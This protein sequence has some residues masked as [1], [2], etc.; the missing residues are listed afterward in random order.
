MN[1]EQRKR[2]IQGIVLIKFIHF[3]G[4]RHVFHKTPLF[5]LGEGKSCRLFFQH[6]IN[7]DWLG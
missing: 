3:L 1:V 2:V 4:I 5:F 7:E 6:A